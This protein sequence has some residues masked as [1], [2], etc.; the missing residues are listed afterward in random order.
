MEFF[1]LLVGGSEISG[2]PPSQVY[3]NGIALRMLVLNVVDCGFEH[4]FSQFKDYMWWIVG[5]STGLVK[6][7]TICGRS[8]V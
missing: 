6:S 8:W 1:F 3:L 7:R 4:R 5:S 2:I